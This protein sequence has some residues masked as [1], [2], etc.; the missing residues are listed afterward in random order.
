MKLRVFLGNLA[1]MFGDLPQPTSMERAREILQ[2]DVEWQF[3][4]GHSPDGTRFKPLKQPRP[5]GTSTPLFHT[6]AYA[7]SFRVATTKKGAVLTST[8]VAARVHQYGATIVPK[9]A[10]ALTRPVSVEAMRSRGPRT[11]PGLFA[12]KGGLF[13]KSAD[14][15]LKLHWVFMKRA[16]IPARPVGFSEPAIREAMDVVLSQAIEDAKR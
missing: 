12:M 4:R 11:M 13:A 15:K 14:G 16:V 9:R 8:H 2:H 3:L 7:K 10:K 6:G 1:G 5:D